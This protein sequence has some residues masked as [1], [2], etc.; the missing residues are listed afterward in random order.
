MKQQGRKGCVAPIALGLLVFA[1]H[2][3]GASAAARAKPATAPPPDAD[4]MALGD[5]GA[6]E[7]CMATSA[8]FQHCP[9]SDRRC[10]PY[11]TM[12]ELEQRLAEVNARLL[13]GS[14]KRYAAIA[15][16]DPQYLAELDAGLR[17]ADSAWRIARDADCAVDPLVQGM[18]R[19]EVADLVESCRV[20]RTRAR[21]D[22]VGARVA[23]LNSG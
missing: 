11:R 18:S 7:A 6:K 2:A 23:A 10:A 9:D 3:A 16:T 20:D 17:R 22:A 1:L 5:V 19:A 12:F 15:K 13:E 21:I 8:D 4:C 14:G